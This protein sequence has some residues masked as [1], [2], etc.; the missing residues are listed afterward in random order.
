M[1]FRRALS[2]ST[3]K[4]S[5]K[6][7]VGELLVQSDGVCSGY[8]KNPEASAESLKDG[9]WC[10]GDLVSRDADGYYWFRGRRK[11]IIIRGGSNISPQEVEEA[12]YTHPEILEAGVV[13]EP[14]SV[15]GTGGGF[16]CPSAAGNGRR[17]QYPRACPQTPGL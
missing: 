6:A 12:L 9:W 3:T 8:W 2:I 14:H 13:G 7:R 15:W 10:T 5:R 17:G 11:E 16:C 1:G 4:T